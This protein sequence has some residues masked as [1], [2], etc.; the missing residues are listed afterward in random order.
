MKGNYCS[1][2]LAHP[3]Y[4]TYEATASQA[5]LFSRLTSHI[6]NDLSSSE[7]HA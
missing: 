5:L 7:L 4:K 1:S 2:V 6:Y 3:L